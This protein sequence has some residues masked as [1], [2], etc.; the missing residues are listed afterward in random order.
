MRNVLRSITVLAVLAV[1]ACSPMAASAQVGLAKH[2]VTVG[3]GGGVSVPVSDAGDAFKNGFN[4]KGF[5][6]LNVP[7]LPVMPRFDL[8]FSRFNLD[9]AQVGVPGTGQILAGLAN[10]QMSVL[11]F[12][13]VRPYIIAGLGAYNL[14]TDTQGLTPS[15][16]SQTHFGVNGGAGVNLHLGMINGFA[17][18]RIDNI[19]TDSGMIDASKVQFVPVT[20]GLTF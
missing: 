16:V 14:K 19:F 13:P 7:K 12:G 18:G 17:E 3:V 9:E 2:F 15:S 1:L 6:R 11:G 4:V 8:D 10:L 5:A 20:F